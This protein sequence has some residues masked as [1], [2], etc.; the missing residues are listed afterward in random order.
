[1]AAARDATT[2]IG[3]R[4]PTARTGSSKPGAAPSRRNERLPH[5]SVPICHFS[6]PAVLWVGL[7][8]PRNLQNS[9]DRRLF[10]SVFICVYLWLIQFS[11]CL[12]PGQATVIHRYKH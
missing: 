5:F 4:S 9:Q 8:F 6:T 11:F 12:K 2:R 7:A 10:L 3:K 1:M